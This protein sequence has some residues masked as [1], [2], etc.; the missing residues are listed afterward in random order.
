MLTI[1]LREKNRPFAHGIKII[2]EQICSRRHEAFQFLS[3]EHHDAA[4][5]AFISLDDSW[6]T[7]DCYKIPNTTRTQRVI[8]ICR[9]QEHE[10][11]MFRPCLYMLPVI[12]REEE[13][14]QIAAKID[15][16]TALSRRGKHTLAVPAGVCKFCTTRHFSITERELLKYIAC[17]HSLSDAALLMKIDESQAVQH[18]KAIMKKLSINNNQGLIRFIRVN[19]HFLFP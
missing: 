14:D 1:A 9:R 13:I 3:A 4:D 18:R 7:A 2:V 11:L 10:R 19:L 16:W 8:L 12:Y 5:V 17:G 15:H 6:I